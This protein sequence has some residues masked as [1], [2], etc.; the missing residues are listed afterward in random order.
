M[1]KLDEIPKKDA[2]EA[3]EGYFESLPGIIQSRVAKPEARGFKFQWRPALQVAIPAL[4]LVVFAVWY[5]VRLNTEVLSTEELLATVDTEVIADYLA[6][7]DLTTEELLEGLDMNL[8]QA[9]SLEFEN[10][11]LDFSDEE[12]DE[13]LND[14]NTELESL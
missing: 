8:L 3:P 7:S 12:I 10:P 11:V 1:K 5:F 6:E 14:Y 2:F 9:D 4:A 13:V